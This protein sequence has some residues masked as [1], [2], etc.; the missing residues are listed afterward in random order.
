MQLY[1]TMRQLYLNFTKI[2]GVM[3]RVRVQRSL[4][5]TT[6]KWKHRTFI[7]PGLAKGP[8]K[9]GKNL[10]TCTNQVPCVPGINVSNVILKNLYP[11]FNLYTLCTFFAEQLVDQFLIVPESRLFCTLHCWNNRKQFLCVAINCSIH[12][13]KVNRINKSVFVGVQFI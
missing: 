7:S 9:D 1:E 5:I 2:S 4:T 11:F 10:C 3:E 8:T 12:K 6:Q 13:Q